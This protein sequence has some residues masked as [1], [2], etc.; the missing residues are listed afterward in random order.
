MVRSGNCDLIRQSVRYSRSCGSLRLSTVV[1]STGPEPPIP[2]HIRCLR[3]LFFSLREIPFPPLTRHHHDV[4]SDLCPFLR[5]RLR[6]RCPSS[7]AYRRQS[8]NHEP[9]GNHDLECR[10]SG[11]CDVVSRAFLTCLRPLVVQ[12]VNSLY[13]RYRDTSSIPPPG[14]FTG[15]LVLGY[16]TSG[17]ENLDIGE[18][19]IC[20]PLVPTPRSV[21]LRARCTREL[22]RVT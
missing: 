21:V 16:L 13:V 3:P 9:D 7:E 10:R 11:H 17:S 20:I 18:L 15:Q 12:L 2:L 1:H 6:S 14:N 5:P 22:A 4:P 19:V 8:A